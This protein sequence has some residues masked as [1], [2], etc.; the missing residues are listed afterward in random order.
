MW[1]GF[2]GWR[3]EIGAAALLLL[4]YATLLWVMPKGAFWHP[5]EGGKFIQMQ[6]LRWD[7]GWRYNV[8]YRGASRDPRLEYY[9]GRCAGDRVYPTV[10]DSGVRFQWPIWFP[11]VT[12]PLFARFGI[13]GL[14]LIPLAGGWLTA[15]LTGI[16]VRPFGSFLA[17]LTMVLVG[18]ATPVVFYSVHFLEHTPATALCLGALL[19]SDPS[20]VRR[21]GWL[22]VPLLIVAVAL[23]IEMLVFVLAMA[24]GWPLATIAGANRSG[25]G[26]VPVRIGVGSRSRLIGVA[27]VGVGLAVA[28]VFSLT[29]RHLQR[30]AELPEMVRFT[31]RKLPYLVDSLRYLLVNAP[32]TEAA[33]V[34]RGSELVA[35]TAVAACFLA[36]FLRPRR[37]ETG[38]ILLG[39][40]IVA[41]FSLVIIL[42]S[43]PY[44]SRQGILTIAPF[45][46]I[47]VYAVPEA[48]R[49]RDHSLVYLVSV[50]L[51]YF[52]FSLFM[53]FVTRV[54]YSGD[55]LVGLEGASRYLLPFYP[56]WTALSVVALAAYHGS[57]RTQLVRSLFTLIVALTMMMSLTYQA[58]GLLALAENRRRIGLWQDALP[59][60]VPVVTDAW[61][62]PAFVAPYFTEHEMYCVSSPKAMSS[63]LT[64]AQAH[65]V[66]RFVFASRERSEPQSLPAASPGLRRES[67]QSVDGLRLVA[68]AFAKADGS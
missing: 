46:V 19:A 41:E 25:G 11:L 66:T 59:D 47:A 12:Q 23:R 8:P 36:P 2:A 45:L 33:P 31:R 26:S 22:A 27:L 38:V 50:A 20:D 34:T 21:G 24:I 68:F 62:L 37:F 13:T 6:S 43:H 28:V 51:L 57:P 40:A 15:V 29:P 60:D 56:L 5:D 32:G 14:Y 65:D 55:Y 9:V 53:I 1:P 48:W 7:G 54:G 42:A 52:I 63:W 30:L 64:F 35:L 49:R 61:W 3:W 58:R 67:E 17:A 44:A 16:L 4:L 18:S 39:L 10:S